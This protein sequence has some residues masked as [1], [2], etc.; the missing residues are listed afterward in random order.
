MVAFSLPLWAG[1]SG[2]LFGCSPCLESGSGLCTYLMF[3]VFSSF[4]SNASSTGTE[5]DFPHLSFTLFIVC[6]LSFLPVHHPPSVCSSLLLGPKYEGGSVLFEREQERASKCK[7]Q[8]SQ[9]TPQLGPEPI[10]PPPTPC[11][12]A[13]DY[14]VSVPLCVCWRYEQQ[15]CHTHLHAA[16]NTMYPPSLIP[17]P[18]SRAQ[19]GV[20][21]WISLLFLII[22][23]VYSFNKCMKSPW[24]VPSWHRAWREDSGCFL[25]KF[26][27]R[28]RERGRKADRQTSTF[29]TIQH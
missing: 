27:A 9:A 23:L 14:E 10:L 3:L 26:M 11:Q 8:S 21:A 17:A 2:L 22:H 29:Q 24:Y 16:G 7:L 15:G 13:L 1:A 4:N 12:I 5:Q 25:P 28:W 20:P 18:L 6:F 19:A